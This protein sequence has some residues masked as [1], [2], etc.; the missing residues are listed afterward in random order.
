M[1]SS[2][3]K[4]ANTGPRIRTFT[5]FASG[6]TIPGTDTRDYDMF[7]IGQTTPG[8]TITLAVPPATNPRVWQVVLTSTASATINGRYVA[9]GEV[10]QVGFDQSQIKLSAPSSQAVATIAALQ[11]MPISACFG[12]CAVGGTQ[13]VTSGGIPGRIY[14]WDMSS[15]TVENG[16]TY[17][18]PSVLSLATPGRWVLTQETEWPRRDLFYGNSGAG[19]TGTFGLA[20]A[21]VVITGTLTNRVTAITNTYTRSRRQAAVSAA[22]AGSLCGW[23]STLLGWAPANGILFKCTF[24]ISDATLVAGARTFVGLQLSTAAPTNVSPPT[25]TTSI[26]VT[27]VAGNAQWSVQCGDGTTNSTGTTIGI[28]LTNLME[29]RAFMAPNSTTVSWQLTNLSTG[30]FETGI[31]TTNA[32]TSTTLMTFQAWR[33]NNSNVAAVGL[34][35]AEVSIRSMGL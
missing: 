3:I 33:T 2:A 18:K 19:G 5:D 10:V 22:V 14:T 30:V 7:L 8:Q 24:A 32:P 12:V 21:N 35:I 17:V 4:S 16:D 9:P 27:Q 23:R 34:D 1:T 20:A 31:F 13:T 25:I 15:T 26:A 28:S 11:A 6:G 29:F